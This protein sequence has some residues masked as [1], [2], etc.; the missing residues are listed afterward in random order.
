ML[1]KISRFSTYFLNTASA[2]ILVAIATDRY[3][4]ICKPWDN[5]FSASLSKYICVGC[6]FFASF[7]TWPAV[8]FFGTRYVYLGSA[9]GTAC[10]LENAFDSSSYSHI[11]FVFMM[12]LTI[13]EFAIISVLYYFVGLQIY[14]HWLFKQKRCSQGIAP[15]RNTPKRLVS[16]KSIRNANKDMELVQLWIQ[17]G[18]H[19]NQNEIYINKTNGDSKFIK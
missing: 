17:N 1:C 10:L 13:F 9:V 5:Q 4:R 15:A 6:I 18:K 3:R 12:S 7:L 16:M 11:Y 14:K 2:A 8:V 19:K